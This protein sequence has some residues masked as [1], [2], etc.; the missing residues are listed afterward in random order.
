M[1]DKPDVAAAAEVLGNGTAV[2]ALL[3]L[4]DSGMAAAVEDA[5]RLLLLL[6][7]EVDGCWWLTAGRRWADD[8][9][10]GATA[11]SCS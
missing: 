6:A 10:V 5:V 4:F 1:A 11:E 3:E 9:A 8:E 2:A 7:D